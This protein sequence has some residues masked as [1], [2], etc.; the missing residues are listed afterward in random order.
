M[1]KTEHKSIYP[2]HLHTFKLKSDIGKVPMSFDKADLKS[3]NVQVDN[4]VI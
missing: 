2:T 4:N 1:H 3:S